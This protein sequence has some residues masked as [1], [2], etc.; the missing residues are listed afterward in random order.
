MN[1]R[2]ERASRES[3]DSLVPPLQTVSLVWEF[4][5]FFCRGLL[6][7]VLFHLTRGP[8]SPLNRRVFVYRNP[9]TSCFPG[10]GRVVFAFCFASLGFLVGPL[11]RMR[12]QQEICCLFV[13]LLGLQAGS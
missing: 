1:W 12:R 10:R 2:G 6:E 7:T 8:I 13:V 3:L 9:C 11:G 4:W 5:T